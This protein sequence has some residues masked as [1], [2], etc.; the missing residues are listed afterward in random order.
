MQK[1][2]EYPRVVNAFAVVNS[3]ASEVEIEIAI[4][5]HV[6][7]YADPSSEQLGEPRGP[8]ALQAGGYA[9]L[10]NT[11]SAGKA[12]GGN[13]YVG[14]VERMGQSFNQPFGGTRR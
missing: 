13:V 8:G 6:G 12:A 7:V 10:D 2:V 11:E 4:G 3:V 9:G 5:N 14:L 1:A